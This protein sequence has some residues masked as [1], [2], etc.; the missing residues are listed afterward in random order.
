[1]V[2]AK[3]QSQEDDQLEDFGYK[4]NKTGFEIGTFLSI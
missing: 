3:I 4:T 1:M 2:F